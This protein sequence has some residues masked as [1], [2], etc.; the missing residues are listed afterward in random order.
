[1]KLE[2]IRQVETF[3]DL[4]PAIRF[5]CDVMQDLSWGEFIA[6]QRTIEGQA[7]K[8]GVSLQ[9]MNEYATQYQV[10]GEV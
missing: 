6:F 5:L 1:M 10:Y 9:Y 4:K 2:D 8:V 7:K 3:E